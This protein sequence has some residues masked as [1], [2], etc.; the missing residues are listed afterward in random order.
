M[1]KVVLK[2]Y[3]LVPESDL[4]AVMNELPNHIANT[5]SEEGCLVFSVV[6]DNLNK[7]QLNVYEEFIDDVTFNNH[8]KRVSSSTWGAISENCQRHYEISEQ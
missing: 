6:Q 2:G 7:N 3:V 8:Q 1:K 4:D 5:Q